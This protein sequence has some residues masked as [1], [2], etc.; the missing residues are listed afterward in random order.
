MEITSA[1]S[2]ILS[3]PPLNTVSIHSALL[4]FLL[5]CVS[6]SLLLASVSSFSNVSCAASAHNLQKVKGRG[7]PMKAGSRKEIRRS[8]LLHLQQT[9]L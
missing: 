1:A 4:L 3:R 8:G 5:I 6:P 7:S 9:I 2:F